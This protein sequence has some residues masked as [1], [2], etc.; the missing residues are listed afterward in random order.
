MYTLATSKSRNYHHGDLRNIL[1]KTT[2]DIIEEDGVEK[3]SIRDIAHRVGVSPMALY[4]HFP[5]KE[6][7]LVAIAEQ[8]FVELR[9]AL[10][11]ADSD[12]SQGEALKAQAIAYVTFASQ[13]RSLF[14]LMFRPVTVTDPRA[15]QEEGDNAYHVLAR[16]IAKNVG[17]KDSEH[18]TIGC[19]ALVHGLA[20]L[21]ID[22][23][24]PD[25][26]KQPIENLTEK[27]II[28]MLPRNSSE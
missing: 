20:T 25:I 19:W 14:R 16:R 7:L 21:I 5:D 24:I 18:L 27:I 8:G 22:N 10:K 23:R 26:E 6:A 1:L 11:K 15:K 4:R 13:H 28:S 12:A 3:I 2:R 17:A 9:D